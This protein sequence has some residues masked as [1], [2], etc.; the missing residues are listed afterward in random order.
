[1][2]ILIYILIALA[3][4][5]MIYNLTFLDLN[6]PMAGESAAALVGVLASGCVILLM[7]ILLLSRRIAE[8]SRR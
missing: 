4:G 7:V 5:L 8:K 2:K 1:M 3:A 6:A